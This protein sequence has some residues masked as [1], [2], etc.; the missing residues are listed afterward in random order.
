[1]FWSIVLLS[2]SGQFSLLLLQTLRQKVSAYSLTLTALWAYWLLWGW[3]SHMNPRM[4]DWLQPFGPFLLWLLIHAFFEKT[5]SRR[6]LV[7]AGIY[8]FFLISL[9]ALPVAGWWLQEIGLSA[10]YVLIFW[11]RYQMF[12]ERGITDGASSGKHVWLRLTLCFQVLLVLFLVLTEYFDYVFFQTL[13]TLIY[14]AFGLVCG[15]FFVREDAFAPLKPVRKY[16]SSSLDQQEK[17]RILTALNTQINEQRFLLDPNASLGG[18]ARK[19]QTTPHQLSQVLNESKGMSFFDLLAYHRVQEAKKLLRDPEHSEDRIEAIGEQVGYLSK[20]SFNTVFKKLTGRT[21]SEFRSGDVRHDDLEPLNPLQ[22]EE[23]SVSTDT[24]ETLKIAGIMLNNFFKIYFRK[25]IR[26]KTF[27]L[28]N[29]FGLIMGIGS[30]LLIS[31]YLKNELSYDRYHDRAQDIY[32]IA[33][34]GDNP[35]TRTPHPMAQALVADF[36]EVEAA[37]SLTPLYGPGLSKQSMYL[38]NPEKD[39][40]FQEPD[41]YAADSTFFQVFDFNLVVGN[42]EDALKQVGGI[43]ITESLARKYFGDENPLG[44][45]LELST[46]RRP[47]VVSG[48]LQDIPENSHFHPKF[49]ISYVTLKFMDPE[50]PWMKWGDYG[51]FNYV[52]LVPGAD[53]LALE[54]KIPGWLHGIGKIGDESFKDFQAGNWRFALQPLVDIHLKSHIRWELEAN[55]NITYVYILIAAIVFILVIVAINFINLST[56]K[57]FERS[58][59]IGVRRT[60]GAGKWAIS[61]QFLAEN[62]FTCLLSLGAAYGLVVLFLPDFDHLTGKPFRMTDFL[63]PD[64]LALATL[65]ILL[66]T[67]VSGIFPSVSVFGIKTSEILKGQFKSGSKGA[68]ARQILVA[69][70]FAVATVMIFGSVILVYQVDYLEGQPLGYDDQVLTVKLQSESVINRVEALEHEIAQLD[71][72]KEVGSISNLPGTQFNQHTIYTLKD[73]DMKVDVSELF[74][75]FNGIAPLDLELLSGRWFDRSSQLDSG[76]AYVI[77]ETAVKQLGLKDPVGEKVYWMNDDYPDNGRIIGVV[78]DFHF[79]SLHVPIQPLVIEVKFEELSYLLVKLK[80]GE[81]KTSIRQIQS[82]YKKFDD[83]YDFEAAFLDQKNE[84]LYQA[85]KRSLVLFSLFAGVALGL[86]ALGLL[87]LAYLIIV[88]RTKEI[89]IRKILGASILGLVAKE[90]IAFLRLTLIGLMIGFP[91]GLLIMTQWLQGFAYRMTIGAGPYLLTLLIVAVIAVMSVT[92]AILRTV[93]SNPTEA[94][95]YE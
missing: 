9:L 71:G 24:F 37:V 21:P 58:R 83:H 42:K 48:V 26:N 40:V 7:W 73:P 54:N 49:I 68:R 14:A 8:P 23:K 38:S 18:L 75:D 25:L 66:I 59:E 52:K 44:K 33:L 76:H 60:L 43:L 27:G 94:L 93:L 57:A 61:W 16:Q 67:L 65:F 77:N 63:T 89:G 46:R 36:P 85:E 15:W 51:H 80:G 29:Y 2:A 19:I 10:G 41:G 1:M 82:V 78:K 72:V 22:M 45:K 91:V 53:A 13:H 17:Y 86:S 92:L 35:Q 84:Q 62:F 6:Q 87:G 50:D 32:R 20:S 4:C 28:I 90:N 95:R 88:Q 11:Q 34:M 39:V 79:Q 64:M 3:L 47:V 70:Q 69:L 81:W 56:A 12:A 31:V 74:T 30:A 5:L 55:G